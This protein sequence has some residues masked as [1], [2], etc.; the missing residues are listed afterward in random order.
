MFSPSITDILKTSSARA[1]ASHGE[2]GVNVVPVSMLRVNDNT[3]WLFNF[4][5]DKTA[6]NLIAN[7]TA[8]LSVWSD[9]KG[10]QVKATC[11]YITEGEAFTEAVE[12]VKE[13]NPSRVV[14]GLIEL[15]PV[16]I[17]DISPGGEFTEED[18]LL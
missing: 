6:N 4:F 11:T 14:K 13:K 15:T 10:I 16:K 5:M 3:I 12:W 1:L 18:L 8:A 17:Y 2:D 7:P 9:M